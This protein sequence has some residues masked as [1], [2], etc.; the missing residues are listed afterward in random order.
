[1]NSL[2]GRRPR[3]KPSKD[4]RMRRL[5]LGDL[6]R[7][8]R[9]RTH[10][11]VLPDDDARPRIFGRVVAANI[12]GAK[13]GRQKIPDNRDMGADRPDAPRDRTMGAVDVRGRRPRTSARNKLNADVAAQTEGDD[14]GG[15]AA[16]DL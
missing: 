14:A 15:T 1:M 11:S 10:G 7:L 4:E 13:R 8:L 9:E 5:R 16:G 2:L 3:V 12:V 6:R